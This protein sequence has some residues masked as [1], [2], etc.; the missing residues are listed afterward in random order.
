MAPEQAAGKVH[1][2]GTAADV[3][4]LGAVLYDVLTGRP[5]FAG[6][7]QAVTL[8]KVMTEEPERPGKHNPSV[9]RDLETVSL[10]C[11]EKDPTK[12]Y[13]TAQALG[14]D[15]RRY[16]RGEPILVRPTGALERGYKWV[17]RN[18]VVAGAVVTV[19]GAL[20]VGTGVSVGFGLQAQRKQK[21]AEDAADRERGETARAD[22]ERDD[23]ITARNELAESQQRTNRYFAKALLGPLR[24]KS[25]EPLTDYERETFW[26][27]VELRQGKVPWRFLEEA[28]LTPTASAQ[29]AAR[30]EFTMHAVIGLDRERREAV[31]QLFVTQ[32]QTL[33]GQ[34]KDQGWIGLSV[35]RSDL[36]EPEQNRLAARA[37]NDALA[38]ETDSFT[39]GQLTWGLSAVAVRSYPAEGG[40]RVE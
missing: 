39:R 16:L 23:A 2:V 3:Y 37:L 38:K 40:P 13:P 22:H 18:K 4:A 9:P 36:L 20:L 25:D 5:P 26:T 6:D 10:K 15:L 11:L 30:A 24:T 14:E 29:L 35:A 7:S 19:A 34:R 32:F 21:D 12:R 28:T 27:L 33:Q 1:E 8:Q 17:R 31:T